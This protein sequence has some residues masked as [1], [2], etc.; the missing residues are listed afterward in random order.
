[1]YL[2]KAP[3][4]FIRNRGF[5]FGRVHH[6]QGMHHLRPSFL[7]RRSLAYRPQDN[8]DRF[9]NSNGGRGTNGIPLTPCRMNNLGQR[10]ER[11]SKNLFS[12]G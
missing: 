12:C 1:V 3:I 7:N 11:E 4:A 9:N 2:D 6:L 10:F 8:A 5:I